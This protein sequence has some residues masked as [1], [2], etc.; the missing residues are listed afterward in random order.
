MSEALFLTHAE[1]MGDC[2]YFVQRARGRESGNIIPVLAVFPP[3]K[4]RILALPS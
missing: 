1:E 4:V 3:D 2:L